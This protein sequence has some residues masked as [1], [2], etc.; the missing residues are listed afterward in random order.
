MRS[1]P[2]AHESS[3]F[4]LSLFAL[5]ASSAPRAVPTAPRRRSNLQMVATDKVILQEMPPRGVA[6]LQFLAVKSLRLELAY[7][8]LGNSS[9]GTDARQGESY[10]CCSSPAAILNSGGAL[11]STVA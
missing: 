1:D 7:K 4:A 3:P 10:N 9:Q 5:L 2:A 8:N 11:T 6:F